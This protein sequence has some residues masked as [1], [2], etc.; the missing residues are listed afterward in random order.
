MFNIGMMEFVL[1]LIIAFVVVGPKDL[2]KVARFIARAI[3]YVKEMSREII[4]SLNLEEELKAVNEIR[5]VKKTVED[6]INPKQILTPI[7]KEFSQVE[8]EIKSAGKMAAQ[9][10]ITGK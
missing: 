6:A 10:N 5:D 8:K 1:L 2:P 9:T 3:R 4:A 7:E